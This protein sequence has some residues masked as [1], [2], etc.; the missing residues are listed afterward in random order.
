MDP[1]VGESSV[2]VLDWI[3]VAIYFG[4][5]FWMGSYFSKRQTSTKHYFLANRKVP[6]WAVGIS[7]FATLISSWAF[8]ALPGKSFRV[9]CSSL[10]RS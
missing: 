8:L 6:G 7:M 1:S 10:R 2:A 4:F 3:I 5:I 9:I